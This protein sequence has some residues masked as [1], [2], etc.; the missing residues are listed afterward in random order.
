MKISNQII[1]TGLTCKVQVVQIQDKNYAIKIYKDNYS[2]KLINKEINILKQLNHTN[3]IKII[4]S[5]I[6]KK[7]IITQLLNDMDL[8]DIIAKDQKPFL[9]KSI[10]YF[11][12][13]LSCVIQYL[14][15]IG[16]VHRDIKLEN[17][18]IDE[19]LDLK[20]CDFGFAEKMD[21]NFVQKCQ[22]T[23]GYLAPELQT[24][25]LINVQDLPKADVYSL[26]VCIFILAFAHPPFKADL[27]SCPF[28]NLIQQRQWQS[29]WALVDKQ[30]K[31]NQDFYSFMEGMLE[32]DPQNRFT[33]EEVVHHPFL[34]GEW[35][36]EF[37]TEIRVR[38]RQQ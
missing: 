30:N 37:K 5:N 12:Q 27:K 19:Y 24:I 35:K 34:I 7:Y 33:I 18:L 17:I 14:H 25:G 16:V 6:E 4:D 23:L 2:L 15:N 21:Q 8:F 9:L 1:G 3:I 11:S 36:E 38:L 28:W 20:L 26:G 10:K 29:Y 13:R 32:Q 22:G 31:F